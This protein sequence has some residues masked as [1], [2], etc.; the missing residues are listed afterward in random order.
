MMQPPYQQVSGRLP[1][2]AVARI[3]K[4]LGAIQAQ[5]GRRLPV[6]HALGGYIERHL[7]DVLRELGACVDEHA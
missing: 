5:T 7:E 6:N 4:H 3:V 1:S 2:E